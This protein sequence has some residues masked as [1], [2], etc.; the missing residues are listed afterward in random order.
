MQLEKLKVRA[1]EILRMI[2]TVGERKTFSLTDAAL[3]YKW[4]R[5]TWTLT[6]GNIRGTRSYVTAYHSAINTYYSA[7]TIRPANLLLKAA[8]KLF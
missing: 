3:G 7:Y 6:C 2:A 8:F 4:K 1:P 5:T